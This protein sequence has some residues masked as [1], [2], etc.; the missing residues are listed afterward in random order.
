MASAGGRA[1]G[2]AGRSPDGSWPAVITKPRLRQTRK[3]RLRAAARA[4]RDLDPDPDEAV[5]VVPVVDYTVRGQRGENIRLITSIL[6][7]GNTTAEQLA[8]RSGGHRQNQPQHP[9]LGSLYRGVVSS[10]VFASLDSHLWV[11]R[12]KWATVIHADKP[13]KWTVACYFGK[14]NK[15][16]N[17]HR[18]FCDAASAAHLVKLSWTDIVQHTMVKGAASPDDPTLTEYWAT[19]RRRVTPPLDSYTL[20]LLGRQDGQ[21]LD[22]PGV[23]APYAGPAGPLRS[24]TS[25]PA[26]QETLGLPAHPLGPPRPHLHRHHRR[27]RSRPHQIPRH[28]PPLGHRPS[29][30]L[31]DDLRPFPAYRRNLNPR[32][33]HRTYPRVINRPRHSSYREPR[34]S[35]KGI[36]HTGPPTVRLLQSSAR[37]A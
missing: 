20:R 31:P 34:P 1:P 24:R 28:R 17:D 29:D 36:P 9:G 12:S 7:A 22:L 6:D 14:Y 30:L 37:P 13:K 8:R 10:A 15:F 19:R 2:L 27:P 4:G 26:C 3:E 33:R 25:E 35:N 23:A 32:R 11:L 5:I 16:R 18:V 21:L